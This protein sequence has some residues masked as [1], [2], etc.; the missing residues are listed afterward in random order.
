ML[1]E[2]SRHRKVRLMV[3]GHRTR[4]AM[5]PGGSSR[6][7][8]SAQL[9]R[10]ADAA[11]TGGRS[12]P[13]H[14]ALRRQRRSPPTWFSWWPVLTGGVASP[15]AWP[16][17]CSPGCARFGGLLHLGSYLEGVGPPMRAFSNVA[18][19]FLPVAMPISGNSLRGRSQSMRWKAPW[20]GGIAPTRPINLPLCTGD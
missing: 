13:G 17:V 14:R 10:V 4:P 20:V 5:P 8:R 6:Q 12:M 1:T 7:G 15:S 2:R 9:P 18:T 11:L 19:A 3:R 16:C